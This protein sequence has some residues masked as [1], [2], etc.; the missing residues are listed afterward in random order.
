M[1]RAAGSVVPLLD[2]RAEYATLRQDVLRAVDGVLSSGRLYLGPE[3]EAF[4]R[5]FAAYCEAGHAVA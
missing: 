3:T 2:L 4:E 1:P 5:E